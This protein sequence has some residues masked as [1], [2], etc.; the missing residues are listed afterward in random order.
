MK[1]IQP[2]LIFLFFCLTVNPGQAQE[3]EKIRKALFIIVDGIAADVLESVNT[4]YI[5]LISGE[6]AYTRAYFGGEKGGYSETPTIS[7]VGYNSLLTGTWANKHNVWDNNIEDPNYHYWT[8][9]RFMKEQYPEKK[10]AVFSTWLD[11]RTKLIGEELPQTG[12]L[13]MDYSFDGLELDT[14]NYPHSDEFYIQKIDEE[15]TAKAAFTLKTEGPD[16]TWVYLQFTDN[17]GHQYGDSPENNQALR[18]IDR[19]V[20][21]I[22]QAVKYREQYFEEDWLVFV[23]TDHGRKALDGKGHGGQSER[24]K[25]I[26]I[27]TN[28][29]KANNY[30]YAVQP[31]IVDLLP[32]IA[33]HLRIDIPRK[34]RMELDGVSLIGDISISHPEAKIIG[35]ELVVSWE[36]HQGDEKVKVWVAETDQ[37]NISGEMDNYQLAGEV[38]I[39]KRSYRIPLK[40]NKADFYKIV[41]EGEHNMLNRWVGK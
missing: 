35:D 17:T 24:E 39:L 26:W 20:G 28:L 22:Y 6:G 37:F 21:E 15:V 7:A 40:K 25:T 38:D 31:A 34:Q 9:F 41:I 30:F 4:P 33:E 32:S 13:K 2:I 16:L 10:A 18:I 1:T 3:Q 5:D 11:N 8:I 23:T 29:K 12:Y 27:S 14:V 19:Q 36:P